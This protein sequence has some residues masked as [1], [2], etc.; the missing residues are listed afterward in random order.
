MVTEYNWL[1]IYK[2]YERWSAGQGILPNMGT[3]TEFEPASLIF[4]SGSTA[5]PSFMSEVELISEVS[6][7]LLSF[8]N[9]VIINSCKS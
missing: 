1:E 5:P 6:L 3:G 8:F 9:I 2:P 7:L 4:E